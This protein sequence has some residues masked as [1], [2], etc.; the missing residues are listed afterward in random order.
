ML[1]TEEAERGYKCNW[2]VGE[3]ECG[4]WTE[5]YENGQKKEE[6]EWKE[7]DKEGQW[8]YWH[9][10]GQKW[11]EGEWRDGKREGLWTSWPPN[12]NK[13]LET[14]FKDGKVVRRTDF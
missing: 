9:E 6:G 3:W 11:A 8:T 12:G 13:T 2:S 4:Q 5:W 7:G 14:E 10:N 1:E